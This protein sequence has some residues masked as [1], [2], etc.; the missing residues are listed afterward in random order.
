MKLIIWTKLK[1]GAFFLSL[2]K[3]ATPSLAQND[4]VIIIERPPWGI[5]NISLLLN[6]AIR[7]AM[8]LA[9]ILALIFIIWGG[10][11]WIVS[12]GD[13]S[14]NEAARN[15]IVAAIVGLIIVAASW[16]IMSLVAQ[17]LGIDFFGPEG[18]VGVF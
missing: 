7:F 5:T 18:F 13:K 10:I 11:Q 14:A 4:E 2:S 8:V 9:I 17:F 15:R 3:L 16:A 12:G 1:L 6:R